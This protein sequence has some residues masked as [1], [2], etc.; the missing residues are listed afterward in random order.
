M[1]TAALVAAVAVWAVVLPP[2]RTR[3]STSWSDGT[4]RGVLHVHSRTSDGG[5]TF[6]QIAA[7]AARAGLQ[8][9][10]V[11]D[12]G[13]G[14]RTPEPPSYHAGVL[15]VDGV[16]VST[17]GGHYI[18]LGLPKTP[19]P[20][21]GEPSDVVED[22]RRMGGFGIVAHPDSPKPELA[23]QEWAAAADAVEVVNLDTAWRR[24]AAGGGVRVKWR[25]LQ[26]LLAYPPRP[27]EAIARLLT[28][29]PGLRAQWFESAESR[30]VVALAGA[31]AHAM[32]ALGDSDPGSG[33]AYL[34][35]PSYDAAFASLSVHVR[36]DRPFSGNPQEDTD[37]L[38]RALR[39][40]RAYVAV[41]GWAS[42]A[43][44]TFTATSEGRTVDAGGVLQ[45]GPPVK[46]G[47]AHV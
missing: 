23:W 19:Y 47:R 11:T 2:R 28:D 17:R 12:H 25:L 41:D 36:T 8:F 27:P 35:I 30:P 33:G 24:D 4:V 5:G 6:D 14:T 18:A 38:L 15:M 42:P 32:L 7:A 45:A 34:P 46:I 22:V 21:G 10:V 39:A 40:G 13:D 16:E 9:V 29:S 43:A 20:L 3:L 31:D 1:V 37:A 44:L 26:A